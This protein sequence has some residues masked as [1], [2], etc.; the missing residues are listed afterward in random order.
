[1]IGRRWSGPKVFAT[2][3][4]HSLRPA[5]FR[6]SFLTKTANRVYWYNLFFFYQVNV[7]YQITMMAQTGKRR[8]FA[9]VK[10]KIH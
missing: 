3:F 8:D 1:M 6:L 5:Y 7:D 10:T 4:R 9:A 2:V